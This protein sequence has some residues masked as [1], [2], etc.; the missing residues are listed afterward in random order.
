MMDHLVRAMD[1][2]WTRCNVKRLGG[3]AA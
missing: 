1:Q 3:V 2:L